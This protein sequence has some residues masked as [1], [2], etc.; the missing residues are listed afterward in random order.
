MDHPEG[1]IIWEANQPITDPRVSDWD[2]GILARAD[3]KHGFPDL[4]FHLPLMTFGV[5]AEMFGYELPENTVSITPNVPRP[6]SRGR[7]WLESADPSV[8]PKIDYR[9]FTDPDGYDEAMLLK[10]LE[11]ARLIADTEPMKSWI[12]REV[13]PGPEVQGEE[14]AELVRRTNH[15]VYHVSGTCRMGAADDPMAVVDPQLRVRGM[16]GLRIVDASVFP[17]LTTINPMVTLYMMGERAA[18]LI[19]ES[20]SS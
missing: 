13:F 12:V 1:L 4:M 5:H 9:Y 20:H 14:L 7:V 3:G 19:R 10:G 11:Y 18:D 6:K 17:V 15:T 2:A 16:D 8:P